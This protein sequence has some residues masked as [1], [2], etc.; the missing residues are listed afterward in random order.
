MF[1]DD[2]SVVQNIICFSGDLLILMKNINNNTIS[3]FKAENVY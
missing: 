1:I 2:V 3:Y